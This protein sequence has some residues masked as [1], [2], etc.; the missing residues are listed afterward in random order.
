MSRFEELEMSLASSFALMKP[1]EKSFMI[2]IIIMIDLEIRETRPG[3]MEE[4][5][6]PESSI[7]FSR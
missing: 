5:V 6:N 3:G 2:Q 4:Y 1:G 7:F